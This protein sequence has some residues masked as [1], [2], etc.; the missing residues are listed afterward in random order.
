MRTSRSR[1]KLTMAIVVVD[2]RQRTAAGVDVT[3]LSDR[4]IR[5][6]EHQKLDKIPRLKEE[7]E[8]RCVV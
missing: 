3:I 5:K 6:K 4:N 1:S 7:L 2:K 8:K